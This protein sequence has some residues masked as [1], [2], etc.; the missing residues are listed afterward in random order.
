MTLE[1]CAMACQNR[2]R[3]TLLATF[4]CFGLLAGGCQRAEL[5]V[6]PGPTT[7]ASPPAAVHTPAPQIPEKWTLVNF[8]APWCPVCKKLEPEL[9]HFAA[10]QPNITYQHVD[11]DQKDSDIYKTY[12]PNYFEGR[13]IPFTVLID[14]SGKAKKQWT[15]YLPYHQM[16]DEILALGSRP[17][18]TGVK[19]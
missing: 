4:A 15:G 3:L 2:F 5:S 8:G 19:P 17:E 14:S 10:E 9:A 11:I 18:Q 1:P 7:T 6:T 13:G 16:V 12:F